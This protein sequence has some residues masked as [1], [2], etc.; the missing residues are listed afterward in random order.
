VDPNE[1]TSVAKFHIMDIFEFSDEEP[2][3][4]SDGK[5][6]QKSG[7]TDDSAPSQKVL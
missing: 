4:D 6:E 3:D 7:L 5:V 2:N 1:K